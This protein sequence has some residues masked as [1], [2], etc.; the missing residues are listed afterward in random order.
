MFDLLRL[1]TGDYRGIQRDFGYKEQLL[2][3]FC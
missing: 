2:E 1:L 3:L